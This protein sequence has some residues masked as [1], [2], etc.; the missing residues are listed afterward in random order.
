MFLYNRTKRAMTAICSLLRFWLKHPLAKRDLWGTILR[1]VSWQVG[2]RVLKMPV[3]IPW[4]GGTCLAVEKGMNA[5]TMNFYCGL[6]EPVDM[7]FILHVLRPGDLF[8]DVG[9]SVGTFTI[10]ASGV[11]RANTIAVEP[12]PA[13]F[14][15]LMRKAY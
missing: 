9:A 12:I 3:I 7:V 14:S 5:A 8:L 11:S 2:V 15:R 1:F 4:V 10:L 6:F 13:T